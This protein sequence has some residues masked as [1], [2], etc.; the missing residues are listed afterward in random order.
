[1]LLPNSRDVLY[2]Y[3][4][5]EGEEEFTKECPLQTCPTYLKSIEHNNKNDTRDIKAKEAYVVWDEPE[6]N[7]TSTST[8]EDEESS[9]TCLMAQNMKSC[10]ESEQ[11]ESSEVYSSN[12]CSNSD[13]SPIYD[14][15]YGAYVE[16][17]EELEKLA[18][19]YLDK[20]RSILEHENKICELQ[21]FIDELKLEN[22]TLDITCENLYY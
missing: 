20:K 1:M 18:K 5:P 14:I 7:T 12:S 2:D 11:D 13:N 21:S 19:K 10:Q 9:K 22:K 15:L 17:H 3:S 6:E 16:M 4:G 8:S